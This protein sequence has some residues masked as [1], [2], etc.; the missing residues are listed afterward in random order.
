VH[1]NNNESV[2]AHVVFDVTDKF[3]VTAGV[4]YS[5]DEKVV[6]LTTPGSRF[7]DVVVEGDNTDY[8][9][10]IDYQFTP[11]ILA[12]ASWSTGYRTG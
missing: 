4:R 7:R 2:F 1:E 6:A 12:Y 8:K 10:G 11:D 5:N 3:A 9:L